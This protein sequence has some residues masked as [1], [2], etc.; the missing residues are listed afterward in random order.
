MQQ[1]VGQEETSTT[2]KT[3]AKAL[4]QIRKMWCKL[5]RPLWRWCVRH[6]W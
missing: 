3:T 6:T 4:H 2:I 1:H 5:R